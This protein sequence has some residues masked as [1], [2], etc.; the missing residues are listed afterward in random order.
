MDREQ[1]RQDFTLFKGTRIRN[2]NDICGKMNIYR[3]TLI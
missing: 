1:N 3:F 2:F